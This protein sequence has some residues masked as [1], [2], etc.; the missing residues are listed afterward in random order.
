MAQYFCMKKTRK[1]LQICSFLLI[2]IASG[3]ENVVGQ[4]L[5]DSSSVRLVKEYI[6]YVYNFQFRESEDNVS[7]LSARHPG[8]PAIYL[9]KGLLV[10]WED[11]PLISNSTGRSLFEANLRKCIEICEADSGP[12]NETEYLLANLCA[13]G[14][15]LLFYADND[16]TWDVIPLA[17]ST[18]KYVRRS[19]DYCE[20]Q[21]DFLYFT[22]IYSYYREAY[23]EVHP[24]YK[25]V[26]ALFLKGDKERG[27]RD[28]KSASKT[29][30]VMN[31]EATAFLSYIY[32]GFENDF[33][34]AVKYTEILHGRYPMNEQ[35]YCELIKNLLLAK[36]FDEAEHLILYDTASVYN[37]YTKV[38]ITIFRGIIQEKKYR[39]YLMAQSL[40][41]EGIIK[42]D[43]YGP[44]ADDI[45]S[46]A[47][48]GLSRIAGENGNRREENSMRRKGMSL[49]TFKS[50]PLARQE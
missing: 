22:G 5:D 4:I 38:Q 47:L 2:L 45:E 50:D 28:L 24:V 33:T 26:A 46:M 43:Q 31:A 14:L 17:A 34:E 23:P 15:L 44:Y 19:F 16:L 1:I 13:R 39:N 49:T 32:L 6:E 25:P 27:L 3:Y 40:Y 12:D 41:N 10:Y 8:H 42:I 21:S 35:F 29:A 20:E 9:L 18:Y 7:A 48:L 36:R 37:P 11:Y 30:I